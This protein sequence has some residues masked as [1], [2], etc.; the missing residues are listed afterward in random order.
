MR[1]HIV[2]DDELVQEA[3]AATGARSKK[4]VI[5]LALQELVRASRKKNL[6][7]LAGRIQFRKDFNHK[8]VRK[9]RG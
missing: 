3:M 9:L 8:A 2:L 6:A 7:D 5:H 1:T 4:E